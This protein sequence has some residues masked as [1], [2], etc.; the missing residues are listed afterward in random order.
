MEDLEL[1]R[2]GCVLDMIE[3]KNRDAEYSA[4]E[5]EKVYPDQEWFDR[6]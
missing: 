2:M 5:E 6:F 3:E 1:L 4:E